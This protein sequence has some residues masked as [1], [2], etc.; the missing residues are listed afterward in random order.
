MNDIEFTERM[1]GLLETQHSHPE[2]A[3]PEQEIRYLEHS[4]VCI[5]PLRSDIADLLRAGEAA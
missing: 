4:A 5:E 1:D 3:W 2:W